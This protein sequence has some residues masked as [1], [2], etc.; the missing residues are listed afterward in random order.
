MLLPCTFSSLARESQEWMRRTARGTVHRIDYVGVS[1]CCAA[2]LREAWACDS[3][4][5]AVEASV[6]HVPVAV[7]RIS[8]VGD[9]PPAPAAKFFSR[10]ALRVQSAQEH[11]SALRAEAPPFPAAWGLESVSP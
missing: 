9:V 2:A 5:I 6:D 1:A 7:R 4:P 11:V 10:N 8:R 3:A